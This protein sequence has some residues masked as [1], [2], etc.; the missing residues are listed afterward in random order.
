MPGS[1]KFFNGMSNDMIGYIVP[2]SQWDEHP[3][4]TYGRK[5]RPYGEVNSLGPETGPVIH[6]ELMIL[7][8]EI[9]NSFGKKM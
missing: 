3:P 2:K 4:F 6:G 8:D 1:Y 5:E 7:L 9:K